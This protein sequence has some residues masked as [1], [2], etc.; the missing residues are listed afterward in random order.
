MLFKKKTDSNIKPILLKKFKS[1]Q[2]ELNNY[3][4]NSDFIWHEKNIH[5]LQ[6]YRQESLY[7]YL[8]I[9]TAYGVF[10]MQNGITW[11][12]DLTD[13]FVE[14][15]EVETQDWLLQCAIEKLAG[16][17]NVWPIDITGLSVHNSI[18]QSLSRLIIQGISSNNIYASDRDWLAMFKQ[19]NFVKKNCF[20]IEKL[21]LNRNINLGNQVLSLSQ[22]RKLTTGNIILINNCNFNLDGIGLFN[23]G[24]FAMQVVYENDHLIFQEWKTNMN[25]E[26]NDN[27]DWNLEEYGIENLEEEVIEQEDHSSNIELEQNQEQQQIV[28]DN[29]N[30]T[31]H[32]FANI[33]INLH[34]SLGQLKISVEEIMQLQQ[35]A[36]LP[37]DKSLPAQVIIYAN[38][39][40]IG[41]GEVID[42]DGKIGVQITN[43]NPD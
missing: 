11:L 34:F 39:K 3:L 7:P 29:N 17:Y 12:Q 18:E 4:K 30:D 28:E 26:N 37:L 9:H 33:P 40:K 27:N 16:N 6:G 5:I 25:D 15:A 31:K 14:H 2:V 10:Y 23:I 42:I 36:I 22:Y 43:L 41:S 35:G 24:S 13:I 21:I 32:P 8:A 38:S 1:A 19:L 20:A